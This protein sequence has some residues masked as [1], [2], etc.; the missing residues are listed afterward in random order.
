M[1]SYYVIKGN[2]WWDLQ[3][4]YKSGITNN[5]LEDND[6]NI[7]FPTY[8]VKILKIKT[9]DEDKINKE[10]DYLFKQLGLCLVNEEHNF[11]FKSIEKIV[12]KYLCD[13]NIWFEPID[14]N[15]LCTINNIILV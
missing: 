4:V 1:Y 7:L 6:S 5:F 11:Y 12:E 10:L 15:E 13:S 3:N 9:E 8:Y 2:K 14:Y